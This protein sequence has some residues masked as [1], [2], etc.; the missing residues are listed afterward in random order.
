M[1]E[2]P[3]LTN[4]V[5]KIYKQPKGKELNMRHRPVVRRVLSL[6][7]ADPRMTCNLFI[8]ITAKILLCNKGNLAKGNK[9]D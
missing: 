4:T 7:S 3:L 9:N 5:F 2:H 1:K 6:T 8:M